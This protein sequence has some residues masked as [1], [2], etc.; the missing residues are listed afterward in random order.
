MAED[1]AA[2]DLDRA[3]I[4]VSS[5]GS[6]LPSGQRLTGPVDSIAKLETLITWAQDQRGLLRGDH[7]RVWVVGAAAAAV[8]GEGATDLG[9][10]LAGLVS[11]GWELAGIGGGAYRL[12]RGEGSP[13]RVEVV[14]EAQPWLAGGDEVVA[15]DAEELG[16][17]LQWWT[18][19]LGT[20]P[21]TTAAG[22]AAVLYDALLAAKAARLPARPVA[23]APVDATPTVK[24][25]PE[26]V[27]DGPALEHMFNTAT[28][29]VWLQQ[30][31]G[32]LASAGML[33]LGFGEPTRLGAA[34]A[35]AAL[36][37]GKRPFGL[38]QVTLPAG[39]KADSPH[40]LPLP[41]PAM[42][43]D[44]PVQAWVTTEDLVGLGAAVRDGG[45]G[46]DLA[47]V[48]VAAAVVWPRQG[49][50]LEAWSTRVREAIRAA[51]SPRLAALVESAAADY[52]GALGDPASPPE[53]FQPVWAAAI[54]AHQ[55]FRGRR[56][57]M[58]IS[59]EFRLWPL[60]IRDTGMWYGVGVDESG[61][62]ID[63]ADTHTRLGRLEVIARTELTHEIMLAALAAEAPAQVI[64]ALTAPLGLTAA[65]PVAAPEP[66]PP[67]VPESTKTESPA[68]AVAQEEPDPTERNEPKPREAAAAALGRR[69]SRK[70][71]VA[72]AD[73]GGVVA[74][75]LD[76]DGLWFPDGSRA[77]VS[78][79]ISHVGDIA[80][81]AWT[82]QLGFRLSESYA[83]PGQIWVTEAVCRAIGIDVDAISRR[84]RN[85]SLRELTA[86]LPFVEL[87]AA[88]GWGFGGANSAK[89]EKAELGTWTRVYR[90]DTPE[91][92]GPFIVLLP[93][94]ELGRRD[95]VTPIIKD[96]SP[97]QLAR[98]LQLF[99]T[100]M[101]FPF[102]VNSGVTGIDLM[103]ECRPK[104]RSPKEWRE[105]VFAPSKTKPPYGIGDI[106]DDFDW[107]RSPTEEEAAMSYLHA[108]DR[109]GSYMAA[110]PGL[111]LPIGDALH[112]PNG[113]DFDAKLPGYWC[114]EVPEQQDWLMPYVLNPKCRNITGPKWV[115]TPRLERAVALGYQPTVI[116]AYV[117]P[118]HG[119]VL[120]TWY[121]RFRDAATGLD[122]EEPD[123]Q[124]A[125]QQSKLVRNVAI[126]LMASRT[127][128]QGKTGYSPERR[129][130][131]VS[132]ASA[133]IAYKIHQIGVDS[134]RW[135]VAVLKDTVYYVSDDPDPVT[136]W[137][138][139]QRS[140][141]RGFGQY[142]PERCG[143]LVDQLKHLNGK[144]YRGKDLL[145]S[146]PQWRQEM[147]AEVSEEVR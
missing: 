87:A 113:F 138:G 123:A 94:V 54:A 52:L 44:S 129:F 7:A 30:R 136:A 64:E 144:G 4:I 147:L 67:A 108:Y 12:G 68:E 143:L 41:H 40:E 137:P 130:H 28:E 112:H 111:E 46:V 119:R 125:R 86:G 53:H 66:A 59:R 38:W 8:A 70:P 34:A 110:I 96:A 18:A 9:P 55:R 3:L 10:A 2:P 76:V 118:E 5:D 93:G 25:Q 90:H 82:H 80:Q 120:R 121:E 13:S 91:L 115:C 14:A 19:A 92:K 51:P 103:M 84:D 71:R 58:R 145:V 16:R 6:F 133:S 17:R 24:I 60:V 74:A 126:G 81:L 37:T 36:G 49:R 31:C 122:C 69:R 50:V 140:L 78:E 132:K 75:V 21:A 27:N 141:G 22:S 20:L 26:W 146:Y 109:G 56:A 128:L 1:S 57:A 11:R 116:E 39:G 35:N 85:K 98:R 61:E 32:A 105:V 73:T 42:R 72:K 43:W 48:H 45:A 29:G 106:E 117:W 89:P 47:N 107:S 95:D 135:P 83:E 77:E 79:A 104:T 62:P 23:A 99:A 142:K 124:A 97:A 101:G 33:S 15:E 131:I 100:Q 114:V 88:A 127:H 134:G 102:K 65:P 63:L 139:D